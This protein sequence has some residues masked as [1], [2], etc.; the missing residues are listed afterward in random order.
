MGHLFYTELGGVAAQPITG[1]HN[2]NFNLFQ[3][4][5]SVGYWSG[6]EYAPFTPYAWFFDFSNGNQTSIPDDFSSH[7]W[8][9][10]SGD[11][12]G[13]GDSP[14]LLP[15]PALEL[16]DQRSAVGAEAVRFRMGAEEGAVSLTVHDVTGALRRTLLKRD[17]AAGTT[18]QIQWGG[19]DDAG[20]RLPSGVYYLRLRLP[21]VSLAR[22]LAILR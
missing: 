8:A 17:L 12:V 18:E 22:K 19:L 9:V 1:T 11:V 4:L 2:T 20:R 15:G 21:S 13:V 10:R 3:N 14:S 5:Q 16:V 7:A 6:T